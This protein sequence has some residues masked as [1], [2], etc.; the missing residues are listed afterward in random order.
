[1]KSKSTKTLAEM[2]SAGAVASVPMNM[3]TESAPQQ[4]A[5]AA[6]RTATKAK[7]KYRN[8]LHEGHQVSEAEL[9]EQDLIIK[10]GSGTRLRP[11]FMRNQSS[12]EA[13]E[14][15]L[16]DL[17]QC[18]KNSRCIHEILEAASVDTIEPWVQE[19]IVK[20]SDYLNTVCE[21][22]EGQVAQHSDDHN[23]VLT[24]EAK[25]S[26]P[27]DKW[28]IVRTDKNGKKSYLTHYSQEH[29]AKKDLKA[30]RD[31]ENI[32]DKDRYSIEKNPDIPGR[33]RVDESSE[34]RGVR[35]LSSLKQAAKLGCDYTYNITES[36]KVDISNQQVQSLLESYKFALA[37]FAE[38]DVLKLFGNSK[39]VLKLLG[40]ARPSGK[41]AWPQELAKMQNRAE[42]EIY[43]VGNREFADREA[44]VDYAR[45]HGGDIVHL[46]AQGRRIPMSDRRVSE[47]KRDKKY[48]EYAIGMAAAKK[49]AG[50]GTKPAKN[51]PKK[52]IKKA[53]EIAR[54]IDEDQD[55]P[56]KR[57]PRKLTGTIRNVER[58]MNRNSKK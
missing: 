42:R 8:S 46:D 47:A 33:S 18:M 20:A 5:P 56:T 51:L 28:V 57:T 36:R 17:L 45:K 7:K 13:V 44:A 54:A 12:H 52:V 11:G 53:H 14:M 15:A 55:Q 34:A 27:E 38:R 32:K 2:T 21:Y 58:A 24:F 10:Q 50:L 40:E 3:N 1:M 37:Q 25:T 22:L 6:K 23:N 30:L 26:Y 19:K 39:N 35:L 4:R 31:S 41:A 29:A 16:S 48:N 9:A 49:Q 43:R